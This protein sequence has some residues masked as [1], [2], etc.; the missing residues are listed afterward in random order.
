MTQEKWLPWGHWRPGLPRSVHQRPGW[1]LALGSPA[2]T[3]LLRAGPS[4]GQRPRS[5]ASP[6]GVGPGPRQ[7]LS[8]LCQLR[9]QSTSGSGLRGTRQFQLPAERAHKSMPLYFP[10][11]SIATATTRDRPAVSSRLGNLLWAPS[12]MERCP[13]RA[14]T[15]ELS[16][17]PCL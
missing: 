2:H 13:P 7:R 17:S 3:Q 4:R 14:C 11:S 8:L 10:K 12:K 6:A 5:H 15:S 9:A 16:S 1:C